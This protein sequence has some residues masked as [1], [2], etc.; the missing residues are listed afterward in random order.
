MFSQLL[1]VH[2]PVI[3]GRVDGDQ[4]DYQGGRKGPKKLLDGPALEKRRRDWDS[5]CRYLR[6]PNNN[7]IDA[8]VDGANVGYFET[9]YAGAP[10]HVDYLQIDWIV[11]H[12]LK[13]KKSGKRQSIYSRVYRSCLL[14][15]GVRSSFSLFM[16]PVASV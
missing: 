16:A 4:S 13:Q 14:T 8:V 7:S 3:S 1:C 12:F 2:D 15:I 6:R 5:F 10:K 11:Q 9:N